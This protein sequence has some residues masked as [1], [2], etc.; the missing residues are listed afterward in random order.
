MVWWIMADKNKKEKTFKKIKKKNIWS[1]IVA[2]VLFSILSVLVLAA[3]IQTLT[4]YVIDEKLSAEYESIKDMGKLYEGKV[5][6]DLSG[7]Y[8]LLDSQ[9]RDYVIVNEA[10]NVLHQKGEATYSAE[11]KE[12]SLSDH[13]ESI[14]VYTDTT[15]R[16]VLFI[17]QRGLV[18]VD[19]RKL[20]A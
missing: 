14:F 12:M 17:D 9:D 20:H 2:V 19:M 8:S 15:E 5:I 1:S 16:G 3:I 13:S 4:L 18:S 6:S 11:K 7:L 10:G